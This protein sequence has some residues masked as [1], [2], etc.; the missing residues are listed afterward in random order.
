MVR[1][2]GEPNYGQLAFAVVGDDLGVG[3]AA[4]LHRDVEFEQRGVGGGRAGVRGFFA[5]EGPAVVAP[6]DLLRW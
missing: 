4:V 6:L 2:G 5:Q 1:R 3:L